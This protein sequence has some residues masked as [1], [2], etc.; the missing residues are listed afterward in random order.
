MSTAMLPDANLNPEDTIQGHAGDH[1][2]FTLRRSLVITD[3]RR[4]RR[5]REFVLEDQHGNI[6]IVYRTQLHD[7]EIY[8]VADW[9][10]PSIL[11]K[12]GGFTD[13]LIDDF[14]TKAFRAFDKSAEEIN[15]ARA[16]ASHVA[17]SVIDGAR[18][19]VN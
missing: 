4:K 19:M 8:D 7:S 14:R 2:R 3:P 12:Y 11:H 13:A 5:C 6:Y 16:I 17:G 15:R 9:V 10:K 18:L 1:Q